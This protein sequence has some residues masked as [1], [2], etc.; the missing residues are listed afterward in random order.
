MIARYRD[1]AA[2]ERTFLAW[3]RTAIAVIALGFFIE[4]FNLLMLTLAS[5][6]LGEAHQSQ[7]ARLLGRI[8]RYDGL[9]LIGGGLGLVLLATNR[10]VR[11]ARLL[12][13]AQVHAAKSV[14]AELIMSG[15]LVLLVTSYSF[16]LAFGS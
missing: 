6:A 13:E 1:H 11:T 16:Y 12:D 10:F 3:I 4:K 9:V 2:N 14:R 8:G 7:I 15:C 5:A